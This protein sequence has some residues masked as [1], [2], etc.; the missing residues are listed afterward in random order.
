MSAALDA[1]RDF[2]ARGAGVPPESL[3]LDT[4]LVTSGLLTSLQAVELVAM[5]ETLTGRATDASALVPG[6]FRDLRSIARHLL[7]EGAIPVL[8]GEALARMRAFD[9]SV[10][11]AAIAH[12]AEEEA[13]PPL[14]RLEVARRSGWLRSFPHL[15]TL[16]APVEAPARARVAASQSVAATDLVSPADALAPAACHAVFAERTRQRLA[17]EGACI[18]ASSACFRAEA[19]EAPFVRHRCFTMREIV[20]VG[21]PDQVTDFVTAW[22]ARL[23]RLASSLGVTAMLAVATDPFFDASGDPKAAA[24]A[25]LGPVKH[26]LVD[27]RG[28]ALASVNLHRAFFTDAF[29]ITRDGGPCWSACVAFGLERWAGALADASEPDWAAADEALR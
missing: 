27:D 17:A 12:G 28:V 14:L 5:A 8:R 15:L 6:T 1:V 18:T 2:I 10:V 7:G 23:P 16:A 29:A 3:A 11:R 19:T 20:R 13:H 24:Q 4:P 21:G 9:A 26:E 25:V 22:Q